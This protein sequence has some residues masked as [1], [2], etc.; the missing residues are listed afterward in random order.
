[1]RLSS[2]SRGVIEAG[3]KKEHKEQNH[4]LD[5]F[6]ECPSLGYIKVDKDTK[7]IINLLYPSPLHLWFFKT[8]PKIAKYL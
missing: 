7:A 1:M 3:L 5:D 8:N 2:G 4:R 6:F